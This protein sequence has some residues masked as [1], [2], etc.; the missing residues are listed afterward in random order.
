MNSAPVEVGQSIGSRVI[1]PITVTDIV[2]YAGASGDFAPMHHDESAARA[3]GFSS[4]F[5]MGMF[6]AGLL[7]TFATDRFG[8]SALR[9]YAIRFREKT[10][11]GDVLTMT[12]TV[13]RV[14]PSD[15][16][17]E[18]SATRSD[19]TVVVTAIAEFAFD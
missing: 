8:P 9:R 3:F 2:R 7:A 17:V 11:V 16:A 4:T 1:G 19:G 10:W 12:G 15:L 6:P 5:S 13:V 14:R 18:L